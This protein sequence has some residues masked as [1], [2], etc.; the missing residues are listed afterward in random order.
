MEITKE[1]LI[2]EIKKKKELSG[3]SNQVVV[4]YLES[5]IK[6]YNLSLEKLKEKEIKLLIKELRSQ[7]RNLTGR[8]QKSTKNR[9]KLLNEDSIKELLAT[10]SSTSERLNFYPEL[11]K[12]IKELKI[13]S[14]LDLGCGLNPLALAEKNI[15][16][17]ASDIKEDDLSLVDKFFKKNSIKGKVFI[18]DIRKISSDLPKAD[19]CLLFK[20]LDIADKANYKLAE[21]LIK[22]LSCRYILV[23]FATKTL[24]GRKMNF[25]RRKWLEHL[26]K[27]LGLKYKIISS[28]NEIFYLIDKIDN[29]L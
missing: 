18:Q 11:K 13:N 17:Y 24:S 25:P 27:N 10:H 23:S 19:I 9:L 26:L 15:K 14:I 16:Y 5:Y 1:K 3:L 12:I 4:D 7:L 6:K 28:D 20:V 21:K 8:F 22:N 2:K 29:L